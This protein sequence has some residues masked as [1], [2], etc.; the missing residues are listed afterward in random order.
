MSDRTTL[1]PMSGS[2]RSV[3]PDEG[4]RV[5]VESVS[6]Q[7]G[8][9]SCG[10]LSALWTGWEP[11]EGPRHGRYSCMSV[12]ERRFRCAETLWTRQSIETSARL[13]GP[14][15]VTGRLRTRPPQAVVGTNQA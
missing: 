10:V 11:G 8:D 2:L 15:P 14:G 9:P 12:H 3:E 7:G 4:R 6:E 1:C 13:V 5:S